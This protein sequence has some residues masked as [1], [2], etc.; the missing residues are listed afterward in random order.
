MITVVDALARG[1][2]PVYS[3]ERG[4]EPARHG[5]ALAFNS[6]WARL[7][8]AT[9]HGLT[10]LAVV[11]ARLPCRSVASEGEAPATG[12]LFPIDPG[13][14]VTFRVFALDVVNDAD[15]VAGSP[16]EPVELAPVEALFTVHRGD[17]RLL[18]HAYRALLDHSAASGLVA[19]GPIREHYGYDSDRI[20]S[21]R[22]V[23]PVSLA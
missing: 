23:L 14:R 11:L 4:V 22:V 15:V 9:R 2:L 21:T 1:G 19:L 16:L 17:H 12:A 18:G 8:P 10:R 13:E 5:V 6:S 20:P 3:I 7:E